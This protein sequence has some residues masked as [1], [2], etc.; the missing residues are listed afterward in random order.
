MGNTGLLLG[1]GALVLAGWCVLAG[2]CKEWLRGT[3]NQ[4]IASTPEFQQWAKQ[5]AQSNYT[6]HY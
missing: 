3:V 2:P 1:L 4:Q 6:Y 5:R